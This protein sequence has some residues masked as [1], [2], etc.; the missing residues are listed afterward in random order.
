[1]PR[2]L[3]IMRRLRD[4]DTG[5]TWQ[6]VLHG[7]QR[8]MLHNP[9]PVEGRML[10]RTYIQDI[11]DK[12]PGKGALIYVARDTYDVDTGTHISTS[13][14]TT[15]ARADGGFGGPAGPTLPTHKLPDRAPDLVD[16]VATLPQAALIYRL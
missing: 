15:V 12:G 13:I 1:M 4:P 11:V 2:L 10:G 16:E 8:L 7:E 9:M 14:S 5:V 6:Q 3:E